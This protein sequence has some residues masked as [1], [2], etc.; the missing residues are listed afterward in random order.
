M[1]FKPTGCYVVSVEKLL[2][3]SRQAIDWSYTA[4][5]IVIIAKCNEGKGKLLIGLIVSTQMIF[6]PKER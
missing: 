5:R 6:V 2:D 4:P 1:T 3:K